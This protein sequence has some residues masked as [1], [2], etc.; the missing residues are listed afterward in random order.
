[1]VPLRGDY[2]QI[3]MAEDSYLIIIATRKVLNKREELEM[4]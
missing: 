4:P 2:Y 3:T 1:V